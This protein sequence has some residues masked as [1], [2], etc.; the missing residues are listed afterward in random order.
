MKLN[1]LSKVERHN[2]WV[3]L[4][5]GMFFTWGSAFIDTSTVLPVFLSTLTTSSVLIG[6]MATIRSGGW[7]LPQMLVASYAAKRELKKPI[8]VLGMAIHRGSFLAL[9]GVAYFFAGRSPGTA[10]LLFFI[11]LTA[12][13]LGDGIG[14]VPYVDITGKT[15]SNERRGRLFGY[16]QAIGGGLAF[17]SG[18]VIRAILAGPRPAYPTN[19]ALVFAIGAVIA[20]GSMIAFSLVKEPKSERK[21]EHGS[22]LDFI[23]LMPSYWESNA[24]FRRLMFIRLTTNSIALTMPFY[25]VFARERLGQPAGAVGIFVSAQMLGS[26]LGSLIL[27]HAGDRLGNRAVIRSTSTLVALCPFAAIAA[28]L[29]TAIGL[30][31]LTF[32]LMFV[33]FVFIGA[34]NSAGWMGYTNYLIEIVPEESRP[35]YTGL[36]N[37]LMIVTSLLAVIGGLCV[38]FLGYT[39]TFGLNL[40]STGIAVTLAIGMVE[41]RRVDAGAASAS[42]KA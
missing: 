41:P 11:F 33:P 2:F 14:G 26:M 21:S 3:I 39:A 32:V 8:S 13:A 24:A 34:Y 40:L 38:Q 31:W 4:L 35:V 12:L 10:L 9:A 7:F 37:T 18:F 25:A 19:F 16:F 5:D 22:F 29:A 23:R 17:L 36:M 30:Q 42:V 20:C 1:E 28:G 27:G 15:V 6:L